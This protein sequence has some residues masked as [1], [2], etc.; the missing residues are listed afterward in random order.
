[1]FH[2]L[3]HFVPCQGSAH[4]HRIG[5]HDGFHRA[6]QINL[7]QKGI[8]DVGIGEDAKQLPLRVGD[9]DDPLMALGQHLDR[10]HDRNVGRDDDI[11]GRSGVD[12]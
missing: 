9:Q 12:I 7:G 8:T 4:S 5:D 6:L 1:L 11:V 10:S 3:Q 2:H